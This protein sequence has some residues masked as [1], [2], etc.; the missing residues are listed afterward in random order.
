MLSC[1]QILKDGEPIMEFMQKI[2]RL[3]VIAAAVLKVCRIFVM[4]G[5][6]SILVASL[7]M[8]A[9]PDQAINL[10]IENKTAMDMNLSDLTDEDL[11]A[12]AEQFIQ[13]GIGMWDV[14]VNE[15][16]IVIELPPTSG[17]ISNRQLGALLWIELVEMIALYIVMTFAEK[18]ARTLAVADEPFSEESI[19]QLK[20]VGFA[21]LGWAIVPSFVGSIIS[22]AVGYGGANLSGGIDL[23]MVVVILL[24]LMLI[25]IFQYGLALHKDRQ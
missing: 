14:S 15:E 9:L 4:I 18:F 17:S 22:G 13:N 21:L 16:G 12:Y 8:V 23:G 11:T 5:I 24:Y 6:I 7:M 2:R 25:Y 19:T 3:G 10:M 20:T 1:K